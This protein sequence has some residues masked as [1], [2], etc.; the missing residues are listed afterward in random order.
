MKIITRFLFVSFTFMVLS[1]GVAFGHKKKF[2]EKGY[3]LISNRIDSVLNAYG[4][5]ST[6]SE[7]FN[8]VSSMYVDGFKQLFKDS[9]VKLFNDLSIQGSLNSRPINLNEY[10]NNVKK[11]YVHGLGVKIKNVTKNYSSISKKISNKYT[12]VVDFDK[13]IFGF[14]DH[15]QKLNHTWHLHMT[16][17]FK[18]PQSRDYKIVSILSTP[19]QIVQNQKENY[20]V[21]S[22]GN[23]EVG[24][25]IL[26]VYSS[27]SFPQNLPDKS[28][29]SLALNDTVKEISKSSKTG[30]FV[31][32]FEFIAAYY[33]DK[34]RSNGDKN[35]VYQQ[36]GVSLGIGRSS[37]KTTYTYDYKTNKNNNG[38]MK[39]DVTIS[40]V[41]LTFLYRYRSNS[42]FDGSTSR[43]LK[44]LEYYGNAGL[45]TSI[46]YGDK[47][48]V[49]FPGYGE[50]ISQQKG[51]YAVNR[52]TSFSF[53]LEGG[54]SKTFG[55]HLLLNLGA[56]FNYY[57][58]SITNTESDGPNTFIV[59]KDHK[60]YTPYFTSYFEKV[61]PLFIGAEIHLA[62]RF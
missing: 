44:Y 62:Y 21:N 22:H 20:R 26:P 53:V 9:G 37:Y 18:N 57:I 14:N 8:E 50:S 40:S 48:I 43:F 49:S 32:N 1:G 59:K 58:S 56:Y 46:V 30:N 11:H 54:F 2:N 3:E 52:V 16:L 4:K 42:L 31:T 34:W 23:Y 10:V 12:I 41:D 36:Q 35:M 13:I 15:N 25:S 28:S 5:Y 61:K 39:N 51:E 19:Q 7:D 33:P 6:F 60:L 45:K 29:L 38:T 27:L 24:F 55:K 17:E 47:S